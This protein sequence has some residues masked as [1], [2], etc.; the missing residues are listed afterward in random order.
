M[1]EHN[2]IEVVLDKNLIVE[3]SIKKDNIVFLDPRKEPFS[4]Y[5][6]Y[7]SE[8]E[9]KY[10]RLPDSVAAAANDG[11]KKAY[12]HTSGGRIRFSTNSEYVAIKVEWD[13]V[14][15]ITAMPHTGSSGFDM[16]VDCDGYNTTKYY[17]VFTPPHYWE[18][19]EGYESV[20]EFKDR[21][22]RFITINFPLYNKVKNIYIGLESG[23]TVGAGKPYSIK[24]PV[25]FYGSS[26][27]QGGYVSR[28]GNTY[29]AILSRR[30][31]FDFL[32]FGF[33]D[34]AIGDDSVIDY[35]SSLD[36]SAFVCDYDRDASNEEFASTHKKT[37]QKRRE[38]HPNIPYIIAAST[39]PDIYASDEQ[40][41]FKKSVCLETYS[42][43]IKQGDK[44]VY[45]VDGD[46]VFKN[47]SFIDC[48]T[49]DGVNITDSAAVK[50]AQMFES[51]FFRIFGKGDM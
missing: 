48:Y 19:K 36:I 10:K 43:A 46:A 34:G 49:V 20:L 37:Y 14:A 12:T 21:S 1:S 44:N 39:E 22:T 16:F 25:A 8:N 33:E 6:L 18:C 50:L 30:L 42:Y 13:E 15:K 28:P 35:I 45:F 41:L 32:N 47:G 2:N 38:K 3:T 23:A 4:I 26:K 24:S 40:K 31:D 27:T 7:N 29:P 51:I 11:V 9:A 5:G 17:K